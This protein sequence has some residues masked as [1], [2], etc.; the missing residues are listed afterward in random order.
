MD[1][2]GSWLIGLA[3]GLMGAFGCG[4]VAARFDLR[5]W[6]REHE[7]SPRAYHRG[8]NL[9]L[10]EQP[11]KALDVFIEAMRQDPGTADLHFALGNLFRRRGEH[12]R[13]VRVHEHLLARGD[14]SAA[15]RIQ[16]QHALA[17]DFLSAGLFDRAEAAFRA[18]E[19]TA[20]A[21]EARLELL[22]LH[23]RSRD[24]PAAIAVATRLQASG[25]GSFATRIA[26]HHCELALEAAARRQPDEAAACLARAR[27]AAP[28]APRPQWMALQAALQ[29]GRPDEA[30]E[31]AQGLIRR[32]PEVAPLVAPDL[33][34]AA[35]SVGTPQ[36]R[37][38]AR[39]HLE[40]A[41]D[42]VPAQALLQALI[43]LDEDAGS[44]AQ[45]LDAAL[46][47]HPS[48]SAAVALLRHHA[49]RGDPLDP[50]RAERLAGVVAAAARPLQRHRCAACGFE[51]QHYF[52][53]CPG[54]QTWD[55]FPP[56][57]LE[58]A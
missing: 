15:E 53:Q 32:Q 13:A 30:L 36:A 27:E 3:L 50:A 49:G 45:R 38:S 58:D 9:L 24:W 57:R 44:Q 52:W 8:L 5:Q 21:T 22:G 54:C 55:S 28:Q 23:E 47:E 35:Q 12:E 37:A 7:A 6:R 19:D 34:R 14:L 25:A 46:A 56:Q 16:A 29:D 4:W 51:A 42:V 11:D 26:H 48:L 17:R 20:F 31:Q 1:F 39:A 10:N 41:L 2:D 43:A 18:L 33:V 40:D